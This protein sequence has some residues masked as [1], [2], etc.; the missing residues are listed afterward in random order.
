MKVLI[1][2]SGLGSR[3]GNYTKYTNKCLVPIGDNAAIS[4]IIESYG[5]DTEFVITLGY[6]GDLV[7][8]FINL[9]HP[10]RNIDFVE[11]D[12]YEGEGSSLLYSI[13]TAKKL[14]QC[15]FI[16]HACDTIVERYT[17]S[18]DYNWIGCSAPIENNNAY[19]S[20]NT[21][22]EYVQGI[23]D[24]GEIIYDYEFIGIFG[25]VDYKHFWETTHQVL[26]THKQPSDYDVLV[27]MLCTDKFK[28]KELNSWHDIGNGSA[29]KKTQ[30]Y[31]PN[32][33]NVLPK[34]QESIFFLQDGVI[35]FFSDETICQN[36][37]ARSKI[38]KEAVPPI[39]DSSDNFYK[40]KF[41][42]G[43]LL[44]HVAN[45]VLIDKLLKW[46]NDILWTKKYDNTGF[47]KTCLQFYKT[48]TI[49][50]IKQ[51][52]TSNNLHDQT[53]VIN[54]VKIPPVLDLVD[55]ID[56]DKLCRT[57]PSDFH[58]DF[59]LDNILYNKAQD[60][61][62][63]LD[64]RQSFGDDVERG[65]IKYDLAKLNHNLILNHDILLDNNFTV[66]GDKELVVD[67][68]VSKNLLNCK[69]CLE[70]FCDEIGISFDQIELLSA[71]I[72]LNMSPL[73]HYPLN[74]FLF[75]FGKYNLYQALY[76]N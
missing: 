58:G 12:N 59:I 49:E 69:G 18:D 76:A 22:G 14:L 68:L 26:Q 28:Y 73:H 13:Y 63:L 38:L 37:V 67:V 36:R 70:S 60:E 75:Y 44:A 32:S 45:P 11:V 2:T 35:K 24:K 64:W 19:R 54:G 16:F 25:I 29:L 62:T 27:Q 34:E 42:D 55:T 53:S 15:P 48:K 7:K 20:I 10:D 65:D 3:I 47:E 5:L 31:Y 51:F 4:H 52:L 71:L 50:R 72:W 33:Y 30:D 43:E 8:Q 57:E 66:N 46:T 74:K 40:Y 21:R 23:N 6:R 39:E 41:C 61:F 56:F 1:T 17:V 9:A